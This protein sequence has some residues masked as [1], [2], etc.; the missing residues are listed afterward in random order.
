MWHDSIL[1]SKVRSLQPSQGDS[2]RK[3]RTNLTGTIR[4]WKQILNT[5]SVHYGERVTDHL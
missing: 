2:R 4:G 1:V 3:N 5:P